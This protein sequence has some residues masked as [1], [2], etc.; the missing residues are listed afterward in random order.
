VFDVDPE[1]C[2][3]FVD[4]AHLHLLMGDGYTTT[5]SEKKV[6]FQKAMAYAEGAM[7]TSPAFRQGIQQGKP[8]WEAPNPAY[9]VTALSPR[10]ASTQH[11]GQYR[12]GL[13]K[14]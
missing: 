1:N 6:F 12:H 10:S 7:F 14:M 11:G 3:A 8:T 9:S 4:L 2:Q 13:S 5:I